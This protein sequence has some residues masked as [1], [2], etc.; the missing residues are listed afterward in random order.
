MEQNGTECPFRFYFAETERIVRSVLP[1]SLFHLMPPILI[2]RAR[3]D[4]KGRE[5]SKNG[6]QNDRANRFSVSKLLRNLALQLLGPSTT[7]RY[8]PR[9]TAH[10]SRGCGRAE[11]CRS[12]PLQCVSC[13]LECFFLL[14]RVALAAISS[15]Y[16]RTESP[17]YRPT[18]RACLQSGKDTCRNG[19]SVS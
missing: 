17:R 8:S 5:D 9:S 11:C 1:F 6:S 12:S 15:L 4:C 2:M 19:T 10:A 13:K 14:M 18:S 3:G 16:G 7:A